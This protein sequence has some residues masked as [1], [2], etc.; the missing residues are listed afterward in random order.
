MQ[1]VCIYGDL[2]ERVKDEDS[3]IRVKR[4]TSSKLGIVVKKLHFHSI[5][6][7]LN[8][9]LN[10]IIKKDWSKT[11]LESIERYGIILQEM[12]GSASSDD[13]MYEALG[14]KTYTQT[15]KIKGKIKK[16]T[17]KDEKEED[18]HE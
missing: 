1:I 10:I 4:R 14:I 8:V 15:T 9:I 7:L 6:E 11:D 17:E 5:D 13:K 12:S 2:M 16:K 3:S 18:K